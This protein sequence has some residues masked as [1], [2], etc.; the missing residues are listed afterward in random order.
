MCSVALRGERTHTEW[1]PNSK[2]TTTAF[3]ANEVP[4]QKQQREMWGRE[5]GNTCLYVQRRVYPAPTFLPGLVGMCLPDIKGHRAFLKG[6]E[7][8]STWQW[9]QNMLLPA[10]RS[11]SQRKACGALEW[12]VTRRCVVCVFQGVGCGVAENSGPVVR[13]IL[14]LERKLMKSPNFIYSHHFDNEILEKALC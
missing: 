11:F 9:P 1:V 8:P 6:L 13:I 14:V 4:E 10:A 2:Q 12:R 5:R 3:P 7:C